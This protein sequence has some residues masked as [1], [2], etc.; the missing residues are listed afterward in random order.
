MAVDDIDRRE[1]DRLVRELTEAKPPAVP[2]PAVSR[3]SAEPA[4]ERHAPRVAR[5]WTSARI[6]MPARTAPGPRKAF[7]ALPRLPELPE[8]SLPALRSP[9]FRLSALRL[10]GLRPPGPIEAAPP[11]LVVRAW[12][13]LAVLLSAAMPYWPYPKTYGVGLLL[14]LFAVALVVVAGTWAAKLTWDER[15]GGAHTVSLGIVLW[16]IALVTK[17]ALPGGLVGS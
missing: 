16:A 14:Y 10:P 13:A 3:T 12:V 6:L 9:G 2:T 8:L 4:P 5:R 7:A 17:E 1:V 11:A 15:L